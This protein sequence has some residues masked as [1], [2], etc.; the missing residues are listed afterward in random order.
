[1]VQSGIST[2]AQHPPLSPGAAFAR[3][4]ISG[5]ECRLF[6]AVSEAKVKPASH[7]LYAFEAAQIDNR[8][9]VANVG[10]K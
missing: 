1:M 9:A 3:I 8:L 6:S 4:P 2:V 10:R 7:A 5:K